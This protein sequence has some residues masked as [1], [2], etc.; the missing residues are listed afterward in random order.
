MNDAVINLPILMFSNFWE[1]NLFTK[2]LPS[3]SS[4]LSRFFKNGESLLSSP[5][6]KTLNKLQVLAPAFKEIGTGIGWEGFWV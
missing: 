1:A 3:T 6:V 2:K 5:E 4:E